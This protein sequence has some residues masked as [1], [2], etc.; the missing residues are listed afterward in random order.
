MTRIFKEHLLEFVQFKRQ[1]KISWQSII[2]GFKLHKYSNQITT[3][4][5]E[6]TF[7]N[8]KIQTCV[9]NALTHKFELNK[10]FDDILSTNA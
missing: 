6:Y 2:K 3:T 10:T 9:S 1:N 7:F 8:E 4:F 5:S